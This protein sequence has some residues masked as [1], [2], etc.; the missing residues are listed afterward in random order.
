MFCGGFRSVAKL[1]LGFTSLHSAL[2][3]FI[4]CHSTPN[5]LLFSFFERYD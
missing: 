4:F 2:S 1:I 5:L 3:C